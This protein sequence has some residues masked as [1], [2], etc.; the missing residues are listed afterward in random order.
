[1]TAAPV[2]AAPSA[3]RPLAEEP[4]FD[5][6]VHLALTEPDVVRDLADLG[7]GPDRVA[8]A[9]G[10]TGVTTPFQV[11]SPAGVE[12]VRAVCA[13]LEGE[14]VGGHDERAPRYVPGAVHR[15][16]F[17][18]DLVSSPQLL[19]HLSHLAGVDLQPHTLPDC[20][21]YV[22]YAP[23]D[24]ER[25]VDSWHVDSIAF[26]IV[27]ML[28]DPATLHGG[29]LEGCEG[30]DD[31]AAALLG[32]VP[33]ALHLGGRDDLPADLTGAAEF[34]AAGWALLQQGTHVVHRAARLLEPGERTTLVLG[35]APTGVDGDDPTNLDYVATWPHPGISAE[36][37]RHA[38]A[39]AAARLAAVAEG[40]PADA[41]AEEAAAALRAAAVD[42]ER[43][44]RALDG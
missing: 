31:A 11:L 44:A 41:T 13:A 29:R 38:A 30:T 9:A 1:M 37:A 12:A 5:A 22:N 36:I 25:A 27:V 16:Q 34:P 24:L 20:Q 23:Q 18:R 10:P 4:V 35:F 42:V 32:T 33:E 39:R 2:P 19:A 17:L 26:D 43:A 14:A 3:Y 8:A 21:A 28:S 40:L 6:A 7:Y 15:S